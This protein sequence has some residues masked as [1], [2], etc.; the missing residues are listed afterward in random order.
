MDAERPAGRFV[1]AQLA[2][3]ACAFVLVWVLQGSMSSSLEEDGPFEKAQ[4]A[5]LLVGAAI[6]VFRLAVPGRGAAGPLLGFV[7]LGVI[8]YLFGR[9]ASWGR[10][11]DWDEAYRGLIRWSFH[12]V[13]V[14]LGVMAARAL[15]R[16]PALLGQM[17]RRVLFCF[18]LGFAV[19]VFAQ[20]CDKQII[21][22]PDHQLWEEAFELYAYGLVACG[23]SLRR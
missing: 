15:R 12:L 13:C 19:F 6:G 1:A 14:G 10:I 11:W 3:L 7:G 17:D 5:M 9:E 16:N 20:L 22:M 23:L 21:H 8:V 18:A 2:L 4:L